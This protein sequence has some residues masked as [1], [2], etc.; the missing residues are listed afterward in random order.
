MHYN[1]GNNPFVQWLHPGMYPIVMRY[2]EYKYFFIRFK[3][4]FIHLKHVNTPEMKS[5]LTEFYDL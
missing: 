5:E 3:A 1:V 4:R 2:V